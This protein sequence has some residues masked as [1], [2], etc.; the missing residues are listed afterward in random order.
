[1]RITDVK[2]YHLEYS[3]DGAYHPTWIPEYPQGTHELE[4]FEIETDEGI[5]GVTASPSFAGGLDYEEALKYFLLGEDPYNVEKVLR[6]I[7]AF[8]LLGPRPWHI[9]VG[10]WDIIGKDTGK[11][12]Y[13]LLGG[14]GSRVKAYASTGEIQGLEERV[15]YVEE[16]VD[17]GF[18]AVK[19]R[20]GSENL[21]DDLRVA[22]GIR[23]EYPDLNIMVDANMGWRVRV[24]AEGN[25]WSTGD[26]L[27]AARELEDMGNVVWLEEPLDRHNYRGLAELRKKT[28]IPIAGGEFNNGIHHFREYIEY[29]SL[30]V[31]Q[32]DVALATG[33]SGAK[34]VAGMAETNGLEFAPHTWTNG[35]GFTAN[36]HVMGATHAR[37]CEYP[38]EPPWTPEARD[39]MLSE[40]IEV[41]DGWVEPPSSPGLGVEIDWD[42]VHEHAE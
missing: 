38:I 2:Q 14:E 1:M 12:I 34:K 27:R 33:V 20:F 39:F 9:E 5:T 22:R 21:E 4:L 42:A 28:D 10:L 32:P 19:L 41:E 29:G 11:P 18:E 35:V 37:W 6:K 31:L 40:P 17:E 13:K 15:E 23:D 25:R 16:R 36:L 26:A 7:E 8:N 3:L 30:D 24:F